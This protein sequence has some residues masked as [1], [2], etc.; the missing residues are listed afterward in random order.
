MNNE[1]LRKLFRLAR[2]E[3]PPAPPEG[4]DARVLAA[5]RREQREQRAAPASLWEQLG[6]LFPRFATAAVL[7]IAVCALA[8]FYF[9]ATQPSSLAADVTELSEQ[10]LFAANGDAH[11]Q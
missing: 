5:I 11:E 6:E 1:R 8:D 3:T 9:S 10:W 7:V 2:T 4:F